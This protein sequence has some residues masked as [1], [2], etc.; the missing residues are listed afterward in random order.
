MESTAFAPVARPRSAAAGLLP[1]TD[2]GRTVVAEAVGIA[3]AIRNGRTSAQ[4]V[5]ELD[6]TAMLLAL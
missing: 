1:A 5:H 6:L 2:G 3:F 4:R